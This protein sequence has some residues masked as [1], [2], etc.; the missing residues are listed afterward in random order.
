MTLDE[1]AKRWF[2]PVDAMYELRAIFSEP[3][4]P[5]TQLNDG[6]RE[7]DVQNS[8]RIA[9][10]R[11]GWRLFR[12]N[13]GAGKLD[14]GNFVRFGLANDSSAVDKIIKSHDLI[15]IRPVLITSD[16][17]GHIIGQFVSLEIKRPDWK[18][19]GSEREVAQL[20]WAQLITALGGY[21]KFSKGDL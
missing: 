21:S 17:V 13:R 12:N 9:A 10:S 14:N 16:H 20:K 4:T 3:Y 18:Y 7:S 11:A 5:A 19:S 15:G 6:F 8:V 2:I 1:W